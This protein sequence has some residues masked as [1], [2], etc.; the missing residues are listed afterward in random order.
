[1]LYA[2]TWPVGLK[3][4]AHVQVCTDRFLA[5]RLQAPRIVPPEVLFPPVSASSN[6]QAKRFRSLLSALT[7]MQTN[8]RIERVLCVVA[9]SPSARAIVTWAA[10]LTGANNGEL[11]LFHAA[12]EADERGSATS[13]ADCEHAIEKLF[14]LTR[15]LPGRPRISAVV[16][17]GDA[18]DEILR[19]A[20]LARA[21]L[22]AVGMHEK[23]GSV[24]PLVTRLAIKA[25][26]PILAVDERSTA[27]KDADGLNRILVAFNFLPASV[28][29]ADYAIQLADAMCAQ[30][31][32][33]HVLP[34]HWQGPP[35]PDPN[36]EETRH[37]VE[38]HFRRLLRIAVRTA[39]SVNHNH[40]E[41]VASG[42]PCVE[43]V[44]VATSTRADLIVMGIDAREKSPDEFGETASCVMRFACRTVLLIPERLFGSPRLGRR[45]RPH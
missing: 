19:H 41:V 1:V 42:R 7:V 11:R 21:D 36:V 16:A 5:L 8:V 32:I 45:E 24:S 34:E 22:I 44:R 17:V 38:Q 35:P 29:A 39:S 25:P 28:A 23:D 31:T 14:A 15:H 26:C 13:D 6:A 3:S 9:F 2:N 33:V 27:P 30:V 18:A 40:R 20:R 43:I 10:S 4:R 12:P 37:M